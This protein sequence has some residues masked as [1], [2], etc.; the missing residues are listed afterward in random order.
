MVLAKVNDG[1]YNLVLMLHIVA[2]I[3]AFAPA[4]VHPLMGAKVDKE[5]GE[6]GTVRF[7]QH[8]SFLGRRVYFPSLIVAGLLGFA[9]VALSDPA[10]SFS[11][12][13]VLLGIA[14][15]VVIAGLVSGGILP[16]E[17]KVAA[18]DVAANKRVIMF[19]QITT[20]FIF[21]QL[22]LMVFKPT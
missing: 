3:V 8:A 7:S 18:G 1:S 22:Y 17:R 13:W 21:T 19:G 14:N 9:L 15:W 4:V 5:D 12:M 16:A 20:L 6:A 10:F 11:D 2:V